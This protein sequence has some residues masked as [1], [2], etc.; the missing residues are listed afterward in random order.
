[1]G[2]KSAVAIGAAR[3]HDDPYQVSIPVSGAET[4]PPA[5][6]GHP[7][8]PG[9]KKEEHMKY[10]ASNAALAVVALLVTA[11]STANLS[12][13][14]RTEAPVATPARS[15]TAVTPSVDF[16]SG[17]WLSGRDVVN[18]NGDEIA[19]ISDFIIDRGS[20]RIAY[21][22]IKSG[23][24]LGM[25]GRSVT[26]PY[27]S[28]QWDSSGKD[29]YVLAL[30]P[31]QLKL[32]PEFTPEAWKI[33]KESIKDDKNALRQKL[34]EDDAS[35][36]DPYAGSLDV[37]KTSH[38]DGEITSVDRVASSTYGQQVVV[39][40][41]TKDGSTKKVA[42]GPSW[43]ING[44][45]AAP[46]RGEQAVIDT[47]QLPRDP[48]ELQVGT[49]LRTAGHE[50]NLRNTDGT[51]VWSQ[52]TVEQSGHSYSTP[53]SRFLVL[54]QINGMKVDCRGSECG[55]VNDTII[56]RNSGEI[57]FV[58]IDPN[59][60]FL[61]IGDTKRLVPWSVATVTL[62]GPMRLDASKQ[63]LMASPETPGDLA[64][65]NTGTNA[66]RVYKAFGVASPRFEPA[67]RT[68]DLSTD[69]MK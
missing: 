4:T 38:V 56:D 19:E 21:A 17:H 57:G 67:K 16:R 25:G 69:P 36:T 58:S 18:N 40:V 55:K 13:Q 60:N 12:A 1:M 35:P 27:G 20:G 10:S 39:S 22:V 37:A 41:L 61:G 31:E 53:Y 28:F 46:M 54:S 11:G 47:L 44:S 42:L 3:L 65:L 7:G 29:R 6:S 66:E 23:T 32:L 15:V 51:P 34:A 26:I 62:E 45:H 30:T 43:F 59:Q 49:R 63:M 5:L 48:N 14:P 33:M 52:K 9:N 50:L 24:T 68:T 8:L 2:D 64:T